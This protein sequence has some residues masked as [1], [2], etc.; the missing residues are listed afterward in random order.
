MLCAYGCYIRWEGV[1]TRSTSPSALRLKWFKALKKSKLT[2]RDIQ[3][4]QIFFND[5]H[6]LNFKGY[7]K[8]IYLE[9][10]QGLRLSNGIVTRFLRHP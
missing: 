2:L 8:F 4:Y 1:D 9:F 10:P 6:S 5:P 7:R 3:K